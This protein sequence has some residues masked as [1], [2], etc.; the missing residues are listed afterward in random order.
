MTFDR[1]RFELKHGA[2][3]NIQKSKA[4]SIIIQ[5]IIHLEK[6]VALNKHTS[7]VKKVNNNNKIIYGEVMLIVSIM[8]KSRPSQPLEKKFFVLAVELNFIHSLVK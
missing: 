6:S 3:K 7:R 4:N 5:S 8:S 2:H 1:Q